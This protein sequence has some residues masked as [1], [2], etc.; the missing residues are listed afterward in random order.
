MISTAKVVSLRFCLHIALVFFGAGETVS[1]LIEAAADIN[2]QLRI[3]PSRVTWWT[4]VKM[5]HARH[6]F[7]PSALTYL[8]YHHYGATP[9]IVSILA[10]EQSGWTLDVLLGRECEMQTDGKRLTSCSSTFTPQKTHSKWCRF[11]V[12]HPSKHSVLVFTSHDLKLLPQMILSYQSFLILLYPDPFFWFC[13]SKFVLLP[14]TY[15][16]T[17]SPSHIR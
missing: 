11:A 13:L 14:S 6:H 4:I 12:C 17:G 5:L 15:L 16:Y 8:A 9:L 10:L 1:S 2:E 7:S 3:P